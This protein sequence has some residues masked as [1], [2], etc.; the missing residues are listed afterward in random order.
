VLG[1]R[2]RVTV[3][4][5]VDAQSVVSAAAP[6]G[7]LLPRGVLLGLVLGV[8]GLSTLIAV[9][10]VQERRAWT[11]P[12]GDVSEIAAMSA[13]SPL[14]APSVQSPP[15]GP[16]AM[17]STAPAVEAAATGSAPATPLRPFGTA[18]TAPA[19]PRLPPRPPRPATSAAPQA[20]AAPSAA[21]AVDPKHPEH[22]RL[23]GVDQ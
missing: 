23:F 14:L 10:L 18:P 2:S 5:E 16:S 22:V 6:M 15:P 19:P 1:T 13:P 7:H 11:H 17:P 12:A 4:P 21:P 3:V 9:V 8:V 20:S